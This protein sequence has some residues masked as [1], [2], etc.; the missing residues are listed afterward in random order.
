[1][2]RENYAML[3]AALLFYKKFCRDLENIGFDFNPY[4]PCV[5]NR[6]KYG[7]QHKLRFHMDDFMYSHVN[8]K[9]NDKSNV[10]MNRN[11]GKY[12]EVKS[13]REKVYE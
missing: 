2:L 5:T 9:G 10:W 4:D 12:D 8:P 7:K 6:I 11:H 13:N 3:V 1:M